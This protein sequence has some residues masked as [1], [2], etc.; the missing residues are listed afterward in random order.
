MGSH[1]LPGKVL[2]PIG[3]QTMLGHVVRRTRRAESLDGVIVATTLQPEDDA[4]V[5]E[6]E[7][8]DAEVF[9]GSE[10]DVLD[11]FHGAA[12]AFELDAVVRITADCPLIDPTIVDRVVAEFL[13]RSADYASNALERT[14]PRG[15]DTEVISAEALAA[16]W[17]EADRPRQR[18]HVTPFLYENPQRFRIVSVR[19][20][21][22][23]S[24]LRWTV[25]TAADLE[26]VRALVAQLGGGDGHD[27]RAAVEAAEL[28]PELT[29]INR[30][31]RQKEL[32]EL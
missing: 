22:D 16:A 28:R 32:D 10:D 6:A 5:R 26:A 17:R 4:V 20:D 18:A 11:R 23:R 29:A 1:R 21:Q 31:V 7:R 12:R 25:D 2:M 14:Y 15:L 13:G 19:A 27:W 9:R 24:H 3:D 30:E 8:L